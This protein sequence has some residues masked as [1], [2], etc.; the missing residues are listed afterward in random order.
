MIV[1]SVIWKQELERSLAVFEIDLEYEGVAELKLTDIEK[2]VLM[3]AF[4]IRKLI[5]S[6][7]L[8]VEMKSRSIKAFS[9]QAVENPKYEHP[10]WFDVTHELEEFYDLTKAN[11]LTMSTKD[12]CNLVIHSFVFWLDDIHEEYATDFDFYINSD[13]TK[14]VIYKI[15]IIEVMQLVKAVTKDEILSRK[16]DRTTGRITGSSKSNNIP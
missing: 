5:G 3:S 13:K 16:Y 10:F 11:F 2:F 9:Y 14:D 1:D 8:S 15:S 4:I 6:D 7:K 12:F